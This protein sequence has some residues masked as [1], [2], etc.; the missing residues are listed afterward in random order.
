MERF[1]AVPLSFC[2]CLQGAE[3]VTSNPGHPPM[4]YLQSLH[5][6]WLVGLP[7][8]GLSQ[9]GKTP[10]PF[11]N[12]PCLQRAVSTSVLGVVSFT[13]CFLAPRAAVGIHNRP[14]WFSCGSQQALHTPYGLC[15]FPGSRSTSSSSTWLL[16][17]LGMHGQ[18]G[19]VCSS[20][21]CKFFSLFGLADS[22][23]SRGQGKGWLMGFR[24]QTISDHE[25]PFLGVCLK[26]SHRTFS[27]FPSNHMLST[28]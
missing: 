7:A 3:G 26:M 13:W 8:T 10:Q 15:R 25:K 19:D 23:S 17:R 1:P 14:Q 9:L 11:K 28:C 16:I 4:F 20:S 27:H 22:S 12:Y 5:S 21:H 24:F 6:P 2:L 18:A